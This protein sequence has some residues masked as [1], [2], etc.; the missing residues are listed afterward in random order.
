MSR[1]VPLNWV[2]PAIILVVL[3][4]LASPALLRSLYVILGCCPVLL[5]PPTSAMITPHRG[6]EGGF[7]HF[8]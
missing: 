4:L 6:S 8:T 7:R 3:Q 2:G 5:V 1:L